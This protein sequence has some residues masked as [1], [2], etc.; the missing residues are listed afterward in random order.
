VRIIDIARPLVRTRLRTDFLWMLAGNVLYSACQWGIIVALAKLGTTEQVGEYALG[1]AVSAPIV[2]FANFQLR[3]LLASDVRDQFT[4]SQYLSFRF[5]SLLAA[6]VVVAVVAIFSESAGQR[7]GMIVLVGLAQALEF[8]SDTYYGYMQKRDRLDRLSRSLMMKGPLALAML[9]AGMYITHSLFWAV[10]GLIAGR[11]VILLLWDSRLGFAGSPAGRRV[12]LEWNGPVMLRLLRTAAPLGIISML[13][14]LNASVPRY[15]VEGHLGSAELGIFSAIMSLITT[16]SLVVSAFGQSI[17]LPVAQACAALDRGRFR[18]YVAG[19]MAMGA[20]LGGA[21]VLAAVLFGKSILTHVFRPEYGE[22]ADVLIPLA[23]AGTMNFIGS[24]LGFVVTA[25]R[26]LRPQIPVLAAAA[27]A[28]AATAAF[29]VPRHGLFGAA[30]AS[31]AAAM[32]QLAGMS[33]ILFRVDRQLRRN[34]SDVKDR[35]A[36]PLHAAKAETT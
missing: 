15:F 16:G 2:L 17:F 19:A 21:G 32:V 12:R 8:V 28:S 7:A 13:V 31:L 23:I 29:A 27:S 22:R 20:V 10:L 11:L 24:G 4:L 34:S 30:D 36:P 18:S 3:A 26:S 25:A 5:V 9:C 14:S 1:M 33:V 6:V 35:T